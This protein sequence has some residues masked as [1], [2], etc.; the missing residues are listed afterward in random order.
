MRTLL[1]L[2]IGRN[3]YSGLLFAFFF[4][5]SLSV[6]AQT[7]TTTGLSNNWENPAA[8]SCPDCRNN[9]PA[10]PDSRFTYDVIIEHDITYSANPPI[11]I[12]NDGSLI[13]RGA[14]FTNLSNL[15]VTSRASAEITNGIIDIGPG[16]MNM[17]GTLTATNAIV[18]KDGNYVNDGITTLNGSCVTL[19]SGNFNNF[20]S[21]LGDGGVNVSAGNLNNSGTWSPDLVYYYSSNVSGLPA[22]SLTPADIEA[23]CA[24]ALSNVG[25][26]CEGEERL[27]LSSYE[28]SAN[29]DGT[30]VWKWSTSETDLLN[31]QL[32]VD[33]STRPDPEV[34]LTYYG[35]YY[36]AANN[37]VSP[38]VTLNI[39]VNPLPNVNVVDQSAYEGEDVTFSTADLGEGFT[40]AWYLNDSTEP[41]AGET[42]NSITIS[43]VTAAMNNDVYKVMVTDGN[44][45]T[46]CTSEDTGTLFVNPEITFTVDISYPVTTDR[47]NESLCLGQ[48]ESATLTVTNLTGGNGNYSYF[49]TNNETGVESEVVPNTSGEIQVSPE[50]TSAYTMKVKDN[51]PN[52]SGITS[53]A[54]DSFTVC[55]TVISNVP[56]IA[57]CGRKAS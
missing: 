49:L 35:F 25:D 50:L 31:D 10:F 13:V 52:T 37:C 16:V 3:G 48:S 36:D 21:V 53:S 14:T 19:R 46:Q 44:N 43:A 9:D 8:W 39:T 22:S 42:S 51:F 26:I 45:A 54:E 29:P 20:G 55:K 32:W 23:A 33:S 30:I 47:T 18:F 40:Y 38:A 28:G 11:E 7:Y 34:N 1:P 15:N 12:R 24:C 27:P 4:L 17:D 56:L 2:T 5:F 41:I 57:T 6:S